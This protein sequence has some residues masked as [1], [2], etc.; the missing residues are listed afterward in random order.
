M[1][2]SDAEHADRGQIMK[3]LVSYQR[4]HLQNLEKDSAMTTCA[5][6]GFFFCLFAIS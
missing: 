6:L 1:T 3:S 4:N 5:V 2:E